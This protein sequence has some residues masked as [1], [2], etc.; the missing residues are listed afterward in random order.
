MKT[1]K[2]FMNEAK[3][4][5]LL[6]TKEELTKIVHSTWNKY[7][8]NSFVSPTGKTAMDGPGYAIFKF[9]YGK[10]KN[11][12]K[13]HIFENDPLS[14]T[15]TVRISEEK[16]VIEY[17][18]QSILIKPNRPNMVYSGAKLGLR[19]TTVKNAKALDKKLD[20][21]FKK[22]HTITKDLIKSGALDVHGDDVVKMIKSKL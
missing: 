10:D 6:I 4:T 7:F 18:H 21:A 17:Y 2:E 3:E 15:I 19:K 8:K 9:A 13:N 22:V 16:I 14:F 5:E 20:I 1:Y 11:E 12:F